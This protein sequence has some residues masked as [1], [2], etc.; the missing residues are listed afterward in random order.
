MLKGMIVAV[1]SMILVSSQVQATPVGLLFSSIKEPV[2]VTSISQ[3]S[4]KASGTTRSFLWLFG[5]GNASIEKVAQKAGIT[6]IKHIDK[7]TRIY[8]LGIVVTERFTVY[9]N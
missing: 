8:P 5:F 2:A 3:A 1:I 7:R 6:E 4:K 9:G